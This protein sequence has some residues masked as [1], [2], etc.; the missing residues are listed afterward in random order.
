MPSTHTR[1]SDGLCRRAVETRFRRG[2]NGGGRLAA[3]SGDLSQLS[4]DG[5]VA[6]P[7]KNSQP[8]AA[9]HSCRQRSRA[10]QRVRDGEA[11]G[12]AASCPIRATAV[13][14]SPRACGEVDARRLGVNGN[15]RL[16]IP[17][18]RWAT[19]QSSP[20]AGEVRHE[21]CVPGV[22]WQERPAQDIGR[23]LAASWS[24]AIHPS[25]GPA[26]EGS[27][28]TALTASHRL[29]PAPIVTQSRPPDRGET[30]PP[31]TARAGYQSRCC[32]Q[33]ESKR[34]AS[35][36]A[37]GLDAVACSARRAPKQTHRCF[38][39]QTAPDPQDWLTGA[40][41]EIAS[42]TASGN[43]S[44]GRRLETRLFWSA[45]ATSHLAQRPPNAS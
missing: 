10:A 35:T 25:A 28:H 41:S 44:T 19:Q 4:P 15:L 1:G 6:A 20:R 33:P 18:E 38:E 29:S 43:E 26:A 17:S 34:T 7:H 16:G 24:T 45:A 8:L 12:V 9:C 37:L 39:T 27:T 32:T 40:V 31:A 42:S 30:H 3:I 21:V 11:R 14:D 5:G 36:T 2:P 22:R 13:D 23:V